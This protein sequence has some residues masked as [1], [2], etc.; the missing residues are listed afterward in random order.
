MESCDIV[1]D[2]CITLLTNLLRLQLSEPPNM[3]IPQ[4][5]NV[6]DTGMG[7][8]IDDSSS[9]YFSR[10]GTYGSGIDVLLRG[11]QTS[12]VGSGCGQ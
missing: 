7:L 6:S 8:D 10:F 2:G 12:Q 11:I 3:L 5:E 1:M 9:G 4:P